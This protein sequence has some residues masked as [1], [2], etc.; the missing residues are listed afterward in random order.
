VKK[1]RKTEQLQIRVSPMQKRAIRNKAQRAGLSMSDWLLA[2]VLS[3]VQ[4]TFQGLVQELHSSEEPGFAFAELLELLG[5]LSASQFQ[6]AVS[7][8]PDAELSPYWASYLAATVEH[9]ASLK[10]V[11]APLWT[12]TVPPLAEP[13][14]GSSLAS[15]RLHLL[16]HSPPAFARRNIFIDSSVGDRV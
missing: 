8:A 11:E 14:F 16:T 12:N 7:E 2:Q 4:A 1:Q 9:A 13:A 5:S 10:H 6:L 15:L 3:P